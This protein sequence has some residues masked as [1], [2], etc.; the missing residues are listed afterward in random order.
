MND[1]KVDI[2]LVIV[3]PTDGTTWEEVEKITDGWRL[4]SSCSYYDKKQQR[5]MCEQTFKKLGSENNG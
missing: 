2:Q 4:I 3:Y 5:K 1:I